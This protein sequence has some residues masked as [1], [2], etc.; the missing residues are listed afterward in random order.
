MQLWPFK[1]KPPPETVRESNPEA[2]KQLLKAAKR[3]D[4]EDIK[5]SLLAGANPNARLSAGM[6]EHPEFTALM[7]ACQS[8]RGA[9]YAAKVLLEAGAD[10]RAATSKG[11]N[12]ILM[13]ARNCSQKELYN[14][15][16]YP[17]INL[18]IAA[19]A[20]ADDAFLNGKTP[21]YM[22]I[23]RDNC[24]I[25]MGAVI[26]L[27][28]HGANPN[29]RTTD[30]QPDILT[31]MCQVTQGITDPTRKLYAMGAIKAMV[32]AGADINPCSNPVADLFNTPLGAATFGSPELTQYLLEQGANPNLTRENGW[33]LLESLR[34]QLD[35]QL[36]KDQPTHQ[37]F[38]HTLAIIALLEDAIMRAPD[39]KGQGGDVAQQVNPT[40]SHHHRIG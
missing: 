35:G 7:L 21:L 22:T 24:V 39:G 40:P 6:Y 23:N 25:S 28:K 12:A 27:L 16:A 29:A 20:G 18:L 13:A 15:Q 17:L 31:N 30:S 37:P 3:G 38:E 8:G 2:D 32:E 26:E 5:A 36:C 34:M 9:F 4:E 11:A 19:G 1:N 33:S 14:T 10:V